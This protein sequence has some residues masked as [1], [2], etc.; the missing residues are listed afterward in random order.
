MQQGL[1]GASPENAVGAVKLTAAVCPPVRTTSSGEDGPAVSSSLGGWAAPRWSSF[2]VGRAGVED[3]PGAARFDGG[4]A[5]SSPLPP[6]SNAWTCT[7][8]SSDV[9]FGN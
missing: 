6:H 7:K 4:E 2:L 1:N 8:I 5:L 9:S 3:T